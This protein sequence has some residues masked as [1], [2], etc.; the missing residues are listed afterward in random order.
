MPRIPAP[1]AGAVRLAAGVALSLLAACAWSSQAGQITHLSGTLSVKRADGSTRLLAVK[2]EIQGGDT[3]TTQSD[4]YAR[5]K[6]VDGGEVVMRPNSQVKVEAFSYDQAKPES[7]S[8]IIGLLK[9]SL[10][11]I[12]G[13]IGKRNREKVSFSTPTAT[14]GIRGTNLGLCEDGCGGAPG[15]HVDVTEGAVVVHNTAG[16]VIVNAGQFAFVKA[17]DQPPVL[18]VGGQKVDIPKAIGGGIGKDNQSTCKF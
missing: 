2:S 7:D 5:V 18:I 3:L 17:V 9:G 14:I 10:R 4:T 15:L 13:L 12:T 6:F 8:A 16:E 11:A 1:R